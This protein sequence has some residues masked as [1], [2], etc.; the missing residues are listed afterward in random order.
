MS[1]IWSYSHSSVKFCLYVVK[2]IVENC[3]Y[4]RLWEDKIKT[5]IGVSLLINSFKFSY[6]YFFVDNVLKYHPI[7]LDDQSSSHQGHF[8]TA[9]LEGCWRKHVQYFL[10]MFH[11]W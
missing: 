6:G 11:H 10:W 8:I 2:W 1:N 4:D 5:E 9:I 7:H 3:M